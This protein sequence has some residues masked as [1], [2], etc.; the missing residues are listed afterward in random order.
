MLDVRKLLLAL[1]SGVLTVAVVVIPIVLF[2]IL[3]VAYPHVAIPLVFLGLF[4][5]VTYKIYKDL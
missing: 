4:V 1:I 5:V 3:L 2:M